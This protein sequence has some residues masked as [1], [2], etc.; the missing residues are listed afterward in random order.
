[1]LLFAGQAGS[2]AFSLFQPGQR[3]SEYSPQTAERFEL[4]SS[5]CAVRAAALRG[6]SKFF[7]ECGPVV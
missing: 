7:Q 2:L 3:S 6:T 1:V 5:T 4:C